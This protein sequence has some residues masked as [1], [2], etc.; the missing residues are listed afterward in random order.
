MLLGRR[1]LTRGQGDS[2][3]CWGRLTPT[4]LLTSGEGSTNVLR[5]VH[6]TLLLAP[7]QAT[8]FSAWGQANTAKPDVST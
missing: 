3:S 4:C 6:T 7:V 8:D 1:A 5:K 2:T